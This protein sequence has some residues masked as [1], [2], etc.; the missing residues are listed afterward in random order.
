MS[1]ETLR[2]CPKPADYARLSGVDVS[3]SQGKAI[4][5]RFASRSIKQANGQE[6]LSLAKVLYAEQLTM[7]VEESDTIVD[8]RLGFSKRT[9][10]LL[11]AFVE[12]R[13]V[14]EGQPVTLAS[15][16][17]KLASHAAQLLHLLGLWEAHKADAINSGLIKARK[18]DDNR[19]NNR[20]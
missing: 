7:E 18:A 4:A 13:E 12:G 15:V 17:P 11:T 10:K 14:S 6:L 20:K 1:V 9:A 2:K 5:D 19:A 16:R 3:Q 8:N